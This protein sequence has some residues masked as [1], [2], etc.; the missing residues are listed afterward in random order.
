[1][2]KLELD[3]P[4][5]KIL[6]YPKST[7]LSKF[8]SVPPPVDVRTKSIIPKD[9]DFTSNFAPGLVVPMPT[10]PPGFNRKFPF[11]FA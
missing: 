8:I 3:P 4:S 11:I 1:M 5:R 10:L 7:E 9:D 2:R 6:Q